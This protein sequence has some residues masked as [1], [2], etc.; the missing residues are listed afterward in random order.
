MLTLEQL[1]ALRGIKSASTPA[2]SAAPANPAAP[3]ASAENAPSSA[4]TDTKDKPASVENKGYPDPIEIP[5]KNYADE[6]GHF[7][8]ID[9]NTKQVLHVNLDSGKPYSQDEVYRLSLQHAVAPLSE[10]AQKLEWQQVINSET[11]F[12]Q[13]GS[14]VF[15]FEE[16]QNALE[17]ANATPPQPTAE[18]VAEDGKPKKDPFGLPDPE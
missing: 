11:L 12:D 16:I 13:F 5:C 17:K 7:A 1:N 3:V 15:T 14:P 18:N 8:Y 10:D 9:A 4:A 6:K 2:T